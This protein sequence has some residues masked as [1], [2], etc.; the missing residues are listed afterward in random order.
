MSAQGPRRPVIGSTRSTAP[1]VMGSSE[2]SNPSSVQPRTLQCSNAPAHVAPPPADREQFQPLT[3]R[4]RDRCAVGRDR[5]T[6]AGRDAFGCHRLRRASVEVDEVQPLA[7]LGE[8]MALKRNGISTA[9]ISCACVEPRRIRVGPCPS[10]RTRG[11]TSGPAG[12]DRPARVAGERRRRAGRESPRRSPRP[13]AR[14][15]AGS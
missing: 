11:A 14:L 9:A 5:D 1:L 15:P 2:T 7:T 6:A 3:G 8:R 10:S 13:R 4:N 12:R